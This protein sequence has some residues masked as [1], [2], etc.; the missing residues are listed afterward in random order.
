M[1]FQLFFFPLK[2]F[3]IIIIIFYFTILY[4]FC[5]TSTCICH[6][7]TRVTRPEPPS[8]L[9]PHT[10]PLCHPSAPTLGFLYPTSNLDWQFIS[11]MVLYMF[12]VSASKSCSL[13]LIFI[14]LT[15]MHF[16]TGSLCLFHLMFNIFFLKITKL[17]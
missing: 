14:I 16:K 3:F 1:E 11:Y 8:H 10:I 17:Q 7:C 12:G 4:W 9:T 13:S 6:G 2:N 15:M 5:H